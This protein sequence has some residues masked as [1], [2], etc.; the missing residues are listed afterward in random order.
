MMKLSLSTVTGAINLPKKHSCLLSNQPNSFV[1]HAL[2]RPSIFGN[3]LKMNMVKSQISS[4]LD[5]MLNY[6]PS[7][8]LTT[9]Q[10]KSIS[11]YLKVS[12]SKL[13]SVPLSQCQQ[14]ISMSLSSSPLEIQKPGRTIATPISIA[15]SLCEQLISFLK[16]L[17]LMTAPERQSPLQLPH[18]LEW[19]L[20]LWP[21]LCHT[22]LG[23]NMAAFVAATAAI[24]MAAEA[25]I[26]IGV[27][28]I[29][30]LPSIQMH[31]VE[32]VKNMV[33]LLKIV[34]Q[35]AITARNVVISS[36]IALSSSGWMSSVFRAEM[37]M[38]SMSMAL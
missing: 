19:M 2:K 13:N 15:R 38:V 37:T 6:A 29:S 30:D 3:C 8:N 26:T 1:F 17:L 12:D 31:M 9:N 34:Q 7:V 33:I 36:T 35:S 20:K 22:S 21:H 23:P 24:I 16:S 32:D 5:S 18:L 28:D 25:E 11:I 4:M 14:K 27:E 10:W